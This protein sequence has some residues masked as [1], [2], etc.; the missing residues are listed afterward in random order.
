MLTTTDSLH[1]ALFRVRFD[2]IAVIASGCGVA[3]AILALVFRR[4]PLW[5][6]WVIG[7]VPM[8]LLAVVSMFV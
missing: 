6:Y 5:L 8:M 3:C 2:R 1:E 7:L 4:F